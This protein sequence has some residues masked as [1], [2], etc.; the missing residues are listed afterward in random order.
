MFEY[1]GSMPYADRERQRKYMRDWIANRRRTW[2]AAN[3]PCVDCGSWEELEVDHVD[4]AT[5]S[6]HRIW[7]WSDERREAELEKCVVRCRHC[8]DIKSAPEGPKGED[9]G[10]AQLTEADVVMIRESPLPGA[11]LARMLG[12]HRATVNDV[13]RGRTWKHVA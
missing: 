9:H 8:H 2:L 13:R 12:V 5:K 7:S 10:M 11:A 1:N 4:P 6:S 3:G